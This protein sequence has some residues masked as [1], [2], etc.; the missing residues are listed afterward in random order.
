MNNN[1]SHF[2]NYPLYKN[3][4]KKYWRYRKVQ[5]HPRTRRDKFIS[6]V[7]VIAPPTL[8][9]FF[10]LLPR[11][12]CFSWYV[13][14]RRA[15]VKHVTLIQILLEFVDKIFEILTLLCSCMLC[16]NQKQNKKYTKIQSLSS[17]TIFKY[18]SFPSPT[19]DD[20]VLV[21]Y[22]QI[23]AVHTP[24]LIALQTDLGDQHLT[25]LTFL[26]KKKC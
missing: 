6:P 18:A 5:L 3:Q 17:P 20:L 22:H 21:V 26:K 2:H 23:Y 7:F 4:I 13:S 12:T 19:F 8:I 1:Y 11:I 24:A 10:F 16:F 9:V 25:N 15:T 14:N